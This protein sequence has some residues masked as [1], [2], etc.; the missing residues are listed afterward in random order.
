MGPS[1]G[2]TVRGRMA[3]RGSVLHIPARSVTRRPSG[4]RHEAVSPPCLAPRT[5]RGRRHRRRTTRQTL[6]LERNRGAEYHRVFGGVAR[7]RALG[8]RR[9][10]AACLLRSLDHRGARRPHAQPQERHPLP[11]HRQAHR[12]HRRQRLGQVVARLR[13]HLRRRPAPLRRVALRLRPP[14]PGADGEAGCGRHRRHLPVHRHPSEEL[15]PQPALDRGHRH[16]DPRLHA[17][18][19]RP[20][21]QDHLPAVRPG[22]DSRDRRGGRRSPAAAARRHPPADWLRLPLVDSRTPRQTMRRS[23]RRKNCLCSAASVSSAAAVSAP[24]AAHRQPAPS[25]THCA[26]RDSG[27]CCST[28]RPCRSTTCRPTP[29][30]AGPAS[31]WS[32]IACASKATCA[33]GSPTRS[34]PPTRRA[35]APR[36]PCR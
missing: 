13:H 5:G 16:R 17:A 2:W 28:G 18:A 34:R 4:R 36:G 14:V 25:W 10:N 23:R 9:S 35:A 22:S 15:G 11:A 6:L 26:G 19:V 7:S 29:S 20:R 30:R 32:W 8:S 24:S 33:R 1:L 12:H 21:G 3:L 31:A 27:A